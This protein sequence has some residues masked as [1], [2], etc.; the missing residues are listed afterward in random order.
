MDFSPFKQDIDE[1]IQEFEQGQLTTLSDMKRIWLDWK[2]SYIFQALPSTNLALVMQTL[3][4]HSISY[5]DI[6]KSLSNRLGALYCLYCLY[7][8]QP[9]K[10]PFKIYLSLGE[11]K[12]LKALV[13]A[14]KEWGIRVVS[15][16]VKRMLEKNA[17]LF[18]SVNISEYSG[19]ERI[20]GIVDTQKACL[21]LLNEKLLGNTDTESYLHMDMGMELD[22]EV[23]MKISKEY[24]A[25]KG[26]AIDE[27]SKV[28]DVQNIEHIAEERPT[29][30]DEVEKITEEWGNQREVFSQQLA[31]T[32][33][34][35]G[36]LQQEQPMSLPPAQ[37]GDDDDDDLQHTSFLNLL[38]GNESPQLNDDVQR[39]L[40]D[41]DFRVD[42][43]NEEDTVSEFAKELE[44]ELFLDY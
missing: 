23:L 25:I 22:V 43:D 15:T 21:K 13:V 37:N 19:K 1:L 29:I 17:F 32:P 3:Y 26:L 16:V 35:K 5:M 7:E 44:S 28:V 38:L 40:A 12:G 34:E 24:E 31:V 27:A 18:G 10:P 39:N 42:D 36:D 33:P 8:T 14:A 2:F 41:Q 4:N 30:G 11:L 20:K 9:F 6:N